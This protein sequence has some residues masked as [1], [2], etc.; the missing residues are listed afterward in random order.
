MIAA[1]TYADE[2]W[3]LHLPDCRNALIYVHCPDMWQ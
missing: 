1:V 3:H 2:Y